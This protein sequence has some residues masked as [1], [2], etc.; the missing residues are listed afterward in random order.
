MLDYKL[1]GEGTK[2]ALIMYCFDT[3]LRTDTGS[4]WPRQ[5]YASGFYGVVFID[6]S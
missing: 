5:R 3:D 1:L 2:K 4:A 6:T